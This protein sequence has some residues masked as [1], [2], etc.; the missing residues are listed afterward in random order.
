MSRLSRVILVLALVG[1]VAALAGLAWL[2]RPAALAWLAERAVAASDGRLRIE[3]VVGTVL[4]GGARRVRWVDADATIEIDGARLSWSPAALLAGRIHLRS[5][6]GARVRVGLPEAARAGP[7]SPPALPSLALPVSIGELVVDELRVERGGAVLATLRALQLRAGFADGRYRVSAARFDADWGSLRD[8]SVE[9]GVA[10]PNPVRASGRLAGVPVPLPGVAPLD[11][12]FDATGALRALAV[13]VSAL[14]ADARVDAR[15]L[16]APFDATPLTNATLAVAGLDPRRLDARL[17]R[18]MLEGELVVDGV[19]PGADPAGAWSGR[20]RL[21][22]ASPAPADAGGLPIVRLVTPV[23]VQ[24]ARVEFDALALELPAGGSVRGPVAIDATHPA[25]AGVPHVRASLAIAGVALETLAGGV[26]PLRLD[27]RV[28]ADGA[29]L[30][31]DLRERVGSGGA[32]G[33]AAHGVAGALAARARLSTDGRVLRILEAVVSDAVTSVDARGTASFGAAPSLTL[34]GT[35]R[36]FDPSRVAALR[37]AS[38]G[39][40]LPD[41]LD[42]D[43]TLAATL[44]ATPDLKGGLSLRDA[45]WAGRALA[46][47]ASGRWR[48]GRASDVEVDLRLAGNRLRAS[49]AYGAPGD[50]L[51]LELDAPQPGQLDARLQGRLRADATLRSDGRAFALDARAS[52]SGLVWADALGANRFELELALPG[53]SV[54]A[55]GGPDPGAALGAARARV[56]VSGLRTLGGDAGDVLERATLEVDGTLGEHRFRLGARAL[57]STLAL[58][59]SGRARVAA[60]APPTWDATLGEARIDGAWPATLASGA[61][62]AL[63]GERIDVSGVQARVSTGDAQAELNIGSLVLGGGTLR[64]DG[65]IRGLPIAVVLQILDRLRSRPPDRSDAP[66]ALAGLRLDADWTFAGSGL[67]DVDARLEAGIREVALAGQAPLALGAVNRLVLRAERGR[68][69]GRVSVTVPSLVF[70]RRYTGADWIVDGRLAF[71]GTIGGTVRAPRFDGRLEGRELSLQQRSLGWRFERGTLQARFD[72]ETLVLESFR[73]GSGEGSL[74]LK[75]QARLLATAPAAAGGSSPAGPPLAGRFTLDAQGLRLPLGPGPRLTLSGSTVSTSAA[76]GVT[77]IGRLRADE[78]LI[79]LRSAG[80][81]SLPEDVVIVGAARSG[82]ASGGGGTGGGR[83][84]GASGGTDSGTGGGTGTGQSPASAFSIGAEL[85]IDLGPAF[86]ITGGGLDARLD[87]VIRLSGRLPDSPRVVGTVNV[88]DGT[89][90]A[91]GQQLVIPRGSVRFTGPVDNPALDIVAVRQFLPVEPGVSITGTAL[92]PRVRLVST[93]EVPDAEKLSW[94]VLGTG[95][96]DARGAAQMLALRQAAATLVGD[97]DGGLSGGLAQR[98][99]LDYF[100]VG[101][102]GASGQSQIVSDASS[103][104]GL[105]GASGATGSLATREVVSVGKRLSSR[106]FVSY[107]QGLR[108]VWNLLR[109]QYDITQRLSLRA[110]TGSESALDLLLFFRY[111]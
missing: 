3:G 51:A 76:D 52:G 87:G 54:A 16:L 93:P 7:P 47:A 23:R 83:E 101:A 44:G 110:Q 26:A 91:Y 24:G 66:R 56:E 25:F 9:A 11:L 74:E 100:G 61:R 14:V 12:A 4:D 27:G 88:R 69:D 96:D 31:A 84:R 98:F 58:S 68:L 18:A 41:R 71:D 20:L 92:S 45:R 103:R 90:Q 81:P 37:E 15:A 107:E 65:R 109:I 22:N 33:L 36:G 35:V 67:D 34:A 70:S 21:V 42:G 99:G 19:P 2:A 89:Y 62:I 57:G 50:R 32:S 13:S 80:A 86:R 97:D 94:L 1:A 49:G 106:V 53:V 59:G 43:W 111:D 29:T 8:A 85:D 95:L 60:G 10:A 63:A 28:D 72:G 82:A 38:G 39:A 77:W 64:S 6:R 73:M 75:G 102:G 5:L 104:L 79:E 17:P 108:G 30:I 55:L 48:E 40:T 105:P 78:G 46:G